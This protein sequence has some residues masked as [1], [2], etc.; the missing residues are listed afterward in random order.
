MAAPD[1]GVASAGSPPWQ[2]PALPRATIA[3]V[4][5]ARAPTAPPPLAFSSCALPSGAAACLA[6]PVPPTHAGRARAPPHL[7]AA[8]TA[9]PSRACGLT[10]VVRCIRA[11]QRVCMTR[12]SAPRLAE[13]APWGCTPGLSALLMPTPSAGYATHYNQSRT[14]RPLGDQAHGRAWDHANQG[15]PLK[16]L[17]CVCVCVWLLC[18]WTRAG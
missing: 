8:P 7:A 10:A 5:T 16:R 17:L 3:P 11:P 15:P 13:S 9:R 6:Q 1:I 2:P 4:P 12:P 14:A 18:A